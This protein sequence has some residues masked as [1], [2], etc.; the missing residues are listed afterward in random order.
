MFLEDGFNN[1]SSSFITK[2]SLFKHSLQLKFLRL[3]SYAMV[4]FFFLF[5]LFFYFFFISIIFN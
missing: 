1:Y 2:R 4:S 3:L 5:F